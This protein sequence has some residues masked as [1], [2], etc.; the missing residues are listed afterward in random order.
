[1]KKN[2]QP[3]IKKYAL[4]RTLHQL[5]KE[6][7]V[8]SD[9]GMDNSAELIDGGFGLYS[10]VNTKK[11]I[12]PVK[13]AYYR[14]ALV[15]SGTATF[16]IGLETFQPLRNSI[17]FGFPGQLFSVQKMSDDFLA[18][19]MLFAEPFLSDSKLMNNYRYRF[20]FFDFTGLQC[21]SLSE[22]EAEEVKGIIHKINTEVK[23]R[24][25]DTGAAIRLYLQLILI[26]ASRRYAIKIISSELLTNKSTI[27]FTRFLKLVSEHFLSVHKVADYAKMLHVSADHL[28]RIIKA[29]S[30]K[31]AHELIDDMILMEARARLMHTSLSVAEI[32][33]ALNFTDPSHFI[34]FFKKLSD[35]TPLQ[36]R[37][38]SE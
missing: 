34:K 16:T 28:N 18:Y 30:D 10:T 31:T 5:H 22:E 9:F 8:A 1:M 36:Y 21:F 13:T 14:I 38:K 26:I 25:P 3:E 33:Y 6:S 19:Y 37:N 35:C 32:A 23:D 29:N 2:V 17:F 11:N 4:D 12:G 15:L 20:P 24:K 7:R 27:I